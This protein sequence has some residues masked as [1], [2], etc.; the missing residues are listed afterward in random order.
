[1]WWNNG[2]IEKRGRECPG[3]GWIRGRIK[4]K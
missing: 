4:K 1:L 3:D 2:Q